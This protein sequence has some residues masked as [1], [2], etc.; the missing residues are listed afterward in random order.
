[1]FLIRRKG[2]HRQWIQCRFS[3][4]THVWAFIICNAL[5][6]LASSE[7][8]HFISD[9]VLA[10]NKYNKMHFLAGRIY[11]YLKKSI[12]VNS[13]VF[14]ICSV[15][16]SKFPFL[17]HRVALI[18]EL[19]NPVVKYWKCPNNNYWKTSACP[20]WRLVHSPYASWLILML[21]SLSAVH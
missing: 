12:S 1:M 5:P 2:Y 7:P 6:I 10:S 21:C 13:F 11:Y 9:R 20:V 4:D 8:V 19:S 16:S 17:N 14:F 3:T 18:L 15:L